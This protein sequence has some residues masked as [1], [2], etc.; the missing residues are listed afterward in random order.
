MSLPAMMK[1]SARL[2]A[3]VSVVIIQ[4]VVCST[5]EIAVLRLAQGVIDDAARALGERHHRAHALDIG[6]KP[7][8]EG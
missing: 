3:S 7:A 6:G 5:L 2:R 4:P 1:R 8:I